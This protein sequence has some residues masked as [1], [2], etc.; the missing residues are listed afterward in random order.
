MDLSQN[1]ISNIDIFEKLKFQ[2]LKYLYLFDN[3]ISDIKVLEEV[4]FDKLEILD[5]KYN[6]IDKDKDKQLILNI[7]SKLKYLKI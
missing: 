1:Q 5:L 3:S 2:K 4:K 7:K 6:K